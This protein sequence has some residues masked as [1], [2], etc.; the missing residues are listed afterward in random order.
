MLAWRKLD[1]IKPREH[2]LA[3]SRLE[4]LVERKKDKL[5]DLW[6]AY[7]KPIDDWSAKR[8]ETRAA[9]HKADFERVLGPDVA[10]LDAEW[11][12]WVLKTYAKK[13]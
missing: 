7:T 5:R 2:M 10:A 9:R 1:D 8:E 4:F 12:A 3:W 6:L 11:R 13:R